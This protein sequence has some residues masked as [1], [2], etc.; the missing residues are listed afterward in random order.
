VW[1]RRLRYDWMTSGLDLQGKTA[2]D[3]GCMSGAMTLY[4][5]QAGAKVLLAFDIEPDCEAQFAIL[6]REFELKADYR[7]MS[8]YD[9][10][11]EADVVMMAGVYYHLKYPLLGLE[12]AWAATK[13]VLLIE[14]EVDITSGGCHA[15]FYRGAYK[16]N[17]SNWWVPT[18]RC[19]LDWCYCLEGARRVELLANLEG[20]PERVFL[21]VWR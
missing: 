13:Q 11:L 4:M 9:L 5:E 10:D 17:G 6:K 8:V 15:T 20:E 19:L 7:T 14:G 21:R 18:L 12:K 16:N 2:I 1:D 3:V